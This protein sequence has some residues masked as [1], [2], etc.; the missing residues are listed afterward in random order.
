V[1]ESRVNGFDEGFDRDTGNWTSLCCVASKQMRGEDVVK[2]F[3]CIADSNGWQSAMAKNAELGESLEG[4][5]REE[6]RKG[7]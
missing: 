3:Q 2:Y 7:E 6:M 4:C 1:S 5:R